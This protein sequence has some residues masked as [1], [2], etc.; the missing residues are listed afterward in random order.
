MDIY[1]QSEALAYSMSFRVDRAMQKSMASAPFL[2]ETVIKDHNT[3][4]EFYF[5]QTL[6]KNQI[7]IVKAITAPGVQEVDIVEPR[8]VGKTS[9]VVVACSEDCEKVGAEWNKENPEPYRI[10]IFG[11]KLGQAQI[12]LGRLKFWAKNNKEGRSLINWRDTTNSKISWH[13]GSEIH[14]VSAS[15]QTETEGF[16]FNK[17][18]IEEAQKIS[19]HAVSQVILP[20]LGSTYGKVVKIGTVRATKNHYW[21]SFHK[22]PRTIKVA[23]HWSI[24]GLLGRKG[25]Y[26]EYKGFRVPNLILDRMPWLQKEKYLLN[27]DFPNLSE[28]MYYGDM[29]YE[30]FLTQYELEWLETEGSFFT[31]DEVDRMFLGD[32]PYED[33]Q[34]GTQYDYHAGIDFATG[35]NQD[36]TSVSVYKKIGNLKRKVYG[37]TWGDLPLP[38]Q[39]RELVN[40]FGPN[41]RFHCKSI[42]GDVGGNGQAIIEDLRAE[43]AMP[44]FGVSFGATDKDVKTVSMNMKTSMYSDFKK[45]NQNGFL[46]HYCINANTTKEVQSQYRKDKREWEA[47]EVQIKEGTVNKKI[48]APDSDRDD[49]CSS[50][51]LAVRACKMGSRV[52]GAQQVL[53]HKIPWAIVRADQFH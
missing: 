35:D 30:D 42:F 6:Y 1:A 53:L 2:N 49:V 10:G 37:C 17:I 28:W 11:P 40:L 50:D 31:K 24:C 36:D 7:D 47:L 15:D 19:D 52:V 16:T 12:D 43:Y 33:R 41:G 48:G 14:A 38:D 13:N 25:G 18:I 4:S 45:D 46:Q 27:G 9:S 26:K 3:F 21:R 8:Q 23:H 39:K 22:N 5:G 32:H 20:M 44:I 34:A 29:E 51:I